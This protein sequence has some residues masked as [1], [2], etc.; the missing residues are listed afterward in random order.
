MDAVTTI[1]DTIDAAAV[2]STTSF[3]LSRW[4]LLHGL[5]ATLL[6]SLVSGAAAAPPPNTALT[7]QQWFESLKQPDE[8]HLPCCSVADCHFATARATGIGYEVAIETAWVAVP[9]DRILER[10]G[11][12]TGRAIV[13][14]RHILDID[15]DHN[16]IIRIFCFVRPPEV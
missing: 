12:P 8:H 1:A 15:N 6:L 4:L 11:N 2:K 13:C 7:Y 14:Y 10:V 9:S 5:V 16:D 3:A